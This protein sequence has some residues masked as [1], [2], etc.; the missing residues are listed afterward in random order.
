LKLPLMS[1]AKAFLH[2][3][4][5]SGNLLLPKHYWFNSNRLVPY[6]RGPSDIY[7]CAIGAVRTRH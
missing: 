2:L 5:P 1:D 7:L 6:I 4:P 3:I